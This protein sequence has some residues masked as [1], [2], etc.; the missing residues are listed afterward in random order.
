MYPQYVEV[1]N[2]RYKINTDFRVAIECNR[3]AED[4]T[5]GDFERSLAIIY[6]LFGEEALNTPNH[7]EKLL[8][9]A[10]MYLLCGKEY[11]E[12]ANEKPDMSFTEDYSY[13]TTS[14]MSDYHIDLDNCSMH[15]WKFMDLMNGLSNSEL[16]DCCI[17]NRIRN[18]RNFDTKDI[19][20]KKEKKK[21][22]KAKQQVALKKQAKKPTKAQ[23]ERAKE[24]F[25]KLGIG[26][27]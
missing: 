10:K 16:G 13:I 9:L 24:L 27:K 1:D 7:Y 22:E 25:D 4:E 5:I 18:L 2:K 14:F 20:D 12:E 23:Q 26:R 17:L 19:K 21:I 3:I 11:D 15:W 8:E 6:T